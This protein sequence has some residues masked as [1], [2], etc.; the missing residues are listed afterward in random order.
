MDGRE[1][2]VLEA[3]VL[4]VRQ[5]LSSDDPDVVDSISMS[6]GEHAIAALAEY[7]LMTVEG[8]IRLGRWTAAGKDF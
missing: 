4:M 2:R 8:G 1:Q 5:Y 7:G 6:A 3:L